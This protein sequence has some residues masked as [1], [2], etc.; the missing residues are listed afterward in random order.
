MGCG[1]IKAAGRSSPAAE[2]LPTARRIGF[3][4]SGAKRGAPAAA[5]AAQDDSAATGGGGGAKAEASHAGGRAASSASQAA[6]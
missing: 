4:K 6:Y 5:A 3:V 2:A 1:Q